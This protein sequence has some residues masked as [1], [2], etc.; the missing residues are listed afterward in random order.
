MFTIIGLIALLVAVAVGVAGVQANTGDSNALTNGFTVFDHTYHGSSGTLFAYGILVG[1][2]GTCGLI[3][4]LAGAWTTSRRGVVAR[5]ELKQSRREMAA[6]RKELAKPAPA[7]TA[8]PKHAAP[9]ATSKKADPPKAEAP[10][11]AAQKPTWSF[12][13]FLHKP[14][15]PQAEKVAK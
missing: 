7:A 10:K 9:A 15:G 11:A 12:N 5:R 3:M 4:L 2:I 8:P 6:A 14:S 13:R 1:A